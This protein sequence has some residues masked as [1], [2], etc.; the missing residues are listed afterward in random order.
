MLLADV[1]ASM[2]IRNKR[3]ERKLGIFL[4]NPCFQANG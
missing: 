1:A 2:K 3:E 4:N